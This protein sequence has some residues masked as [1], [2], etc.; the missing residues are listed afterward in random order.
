M[1]LQTKTLRDLVASCVVTG[2]TINSLTLNQTTTTDLVRACI[3]EGTIITPFTGYT[4]DYQIS[5]Y[6]ISQS[7][8]AATFYQF[9]V[10]TGATMV[11]LTTGNTY[12]STY[13]ASGNTVPTGTTVTDVVTAFTGSTSETANAL[14]VSI[15]GGS[16]TFTNLY[17]TGN[18]SVSGTSYEVD[19]YIVNEMYIGPK[20]QTNSWR[21]I[22]SNTNLLVQVF[23]GL[24]WITKGTFTGV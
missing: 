4:H 15:N 1:G 8:S 22:I 14:N 7:H 17:V 24:N 20:G 5:G 12:L 11:T 9:Y 23:D 6:T 19:E 10:N 3:T 13:I 21:F 18:L 16:P 2:D